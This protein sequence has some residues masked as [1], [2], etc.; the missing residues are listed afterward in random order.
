MTFSLVLVNNTPYASKPTIPLM[1]DGDNDNYDITVNGFGRL[2]S[3]AK[4]YYVIDALLNDDIQG[5]T[6]TVELIIGR[7]NSSTSQKTKDVIADLITLF[8]PIINEYAVNLRDKKCDS[9]M[10]ALKTKRVLF[11]L[12]LTE[13]QGLSLI[14][15]LCSYMIP[16]TLVSKYIKYENTVQN[17]ISDV[18]YYLM[19]QQKNELGNN[20]PNV[21]NN[22]YK[23]SPLPLLVA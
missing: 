2:V 11:N 17:M 21:D 19:S 6:N 5:K 3:A 8:R 7:L 13:L 15:T 10:D 20:I 14:T 12:K 4:E 22:S 1:S 9:L 18:L 23:I 16:F